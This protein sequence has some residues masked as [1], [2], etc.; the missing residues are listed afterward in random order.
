LAPAAAGLVPSFV[1]VLAT[2]AEQA[3]VLASSLPQATAEPQPPAPPR[4]M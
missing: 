3:L 4:E 1:P 2:V